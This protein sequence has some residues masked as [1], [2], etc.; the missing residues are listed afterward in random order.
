MA[1][2]LH[3]VLTDPDESTERDI[4]IRDADSFLLVRAPNDLTDLA[5]LRD[6]A[7]RDGSTREVTV[8]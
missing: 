5:G 3:A 4:E 1:Q 6:L 8:S 7:H 2:T